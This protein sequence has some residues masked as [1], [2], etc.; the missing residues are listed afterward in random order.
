MECFLCLNTHMYNL[1]RKRLL[2]S[3]P[4]HTCMQTCFYHSF[5][6]S[7]LEYS[8][9]YV[10]CVL[11][12]CLLLTGIDSFADSCDFSSLS[13]TVFLT[14]DYFLLKYERLCIPKQDLY[15]YAFVRFSYLIFAEHDISAHIT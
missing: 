15:V 5:Y 4:S 3:F 2:D 12:L 13:L 11:V 6:K 9:S 14:T 7:C 8:A 1:K 10:Y